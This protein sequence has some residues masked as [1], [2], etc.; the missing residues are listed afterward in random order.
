MGMYKSNKDKFVFLLLAYASTLALPRQVV[1]QDVKTISYEVQR[2]ESL[3]DITSRYNITEDELKSQNPDFELFYTGMTLNIP[4]KAAAET[5]VNATVNGTGMDAND[6]ERI[7]GYISETV[8]ADEILS[9][10][11]NKRANKAYTAIIKKYGDISK[12]TDA[13]YGRA[14]SSYNRG[15]WKAAIKD[16]ETALGDSEFNGAERRQCNRLLAEAKQKRE[17]QLERRGEMWAGL[18][19][20]GVAT[21]ASVMSAKEASKSQKASSS[22]SSSRSHSSSSG[23]GDDDD[24]G[25]T[26]TSSSSGQRKC[27]VCGGKGSIVEYTAHYGIDERPYCDECGKTVTSGHYHK[28][29][30]HCYGTGYR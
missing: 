8:S 17:E 20:V 5:A 29:C 19:Q 7:L 13:Y 4:V 11:D 28:T 9:S 16:F 3:E 30:S 10:G 6:D 2:G 24:G 25:D 26:V 12:C 21:A 22:S 14:L 15:K 18:F 23:G 27:G 1:A